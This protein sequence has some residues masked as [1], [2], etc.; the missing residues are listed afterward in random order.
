MTRLPRENL[1]P[2][3]CSVIF[4][5]TRPF[6]EWSEAKVPGGQSDGRLGE[7]LEDSGYLGRQPPRPTASHTRLD[8]QLLGVLTAAALAGNRVDA[9]RLTVAFTVLFV[10]VAAY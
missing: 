8:R 3:I 9:A 5:C 6:S 4:L 10:A 7:F 2:I 1:A